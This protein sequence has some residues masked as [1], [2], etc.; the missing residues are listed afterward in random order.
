M[1]LLEISLMQMFRKCAT[2][3]NV[4]TVVTIT[5]RNVSL[6]TNTNELNFSSNFKTKCIT[7]AKS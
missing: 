5:F 7:L 2:G 4:T 3:S 1:K 6:C